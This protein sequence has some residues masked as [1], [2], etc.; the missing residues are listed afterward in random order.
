MTNKTGKIEVQRLEHHYRAEA[1]SHEN[2][3]S[4]KI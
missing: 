3:Y 2:S 4:I 1:Y